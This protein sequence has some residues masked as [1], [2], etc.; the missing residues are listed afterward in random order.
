MCVCVCADSLSASL[1]AITV[2]TE[3]TEEELKPHLDTVL[4]SLL[5]KS[6]FWS[7][8]EPRATR[9]YR[10]LFPW[11]VFISSSLPPPTKTDGCC[12]SCTTNANP[13]APRSVAA[14]SCCELPW[15]YTTVSSA[16]LYLQT[17]GRLLTSRLNKTGSSIEP[18]GTPAELMRCEDGADS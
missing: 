16:F 4:A 1:N 3:L 7:S 2:S 6:K 18:C 10:G 5:E 8:P 15:H 17:F 14:A 9:L 13:I 11:T 12:P